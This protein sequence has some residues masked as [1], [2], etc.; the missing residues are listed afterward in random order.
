MGQS[1]KTKLETDIKFKKYTNQILESEQV[2]GKEF[3]S[4][5]MIHP[6]LGTSFLLINSL[7]IGSISFYKLGVCKNSIITLGFI[8]YVNAAWNL[9]AI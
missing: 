7:L 1:I 3:E 8:I 2:L 4:L 6:K 5:D 9:F